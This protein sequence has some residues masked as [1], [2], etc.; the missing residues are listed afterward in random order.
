[1]KHKTLLIS[2]K[3]RMPAIEKR[4]PYGCGC[5]AY[6][7]VFTATFQLRVSFLLVS[8]VNIIMAGLLLPQPCYASN[9]KTPETSKIET[10]KI[11]TSKIETS[12]IETLHTPVLMLSLLW[13]PV[14]MMIMWK[15]N[16]YITQKYWKKKY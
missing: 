15:K 2:R 6:R 9:D 5:R 13:M 8:V 3:E 11:E 1:V 4:Q 10:S 7:D 16:R 14:Q 12:K